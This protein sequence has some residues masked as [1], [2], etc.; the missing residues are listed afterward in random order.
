M[1]AIV[2]PD[3]EEHTQAEPLGDASDGAPGSLEDHYVRH[4]PEAVRLAYLLTG[5]ASLAEDLAHEAFIKVA[6]YGSPGLTRKRS[7]NESSS[8]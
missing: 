3:S 8:A 5:D 1:N 4:A 7:P 6:G 2:G